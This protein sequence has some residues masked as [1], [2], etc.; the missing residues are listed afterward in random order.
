[1]AELLSAPYPKPTSVLLEHAEEDMLQHGCAGEMVPT[2][3]RWQ[4]GRLAR[5]LLFTTA[6][7]WTTHHY[8]VE[9]IRFGESERMN[10][11]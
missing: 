11:L 8:C 3:A 10:S 1:M 4:L 2:D 9:H 6:W 5:C 7:E